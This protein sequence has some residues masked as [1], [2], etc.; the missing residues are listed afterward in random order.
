MA[1]EGIPQPTLKG[2]DGREWEIRVRLAE[3]VAATEYVLFE[4]DTEKHKELWGKIAD[5][6]AD[7]KPELPLFKI[8]RRV[9]K[10]RLGPF[11][12]AFILE[13]GREP[14]DRDLDAEWLDIRTQLGGFA[15]WLVVM[16]FLASSEGSEFLAYMNAM[17]PTLQKAAQERL[18]ATK[19]AAK[20]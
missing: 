3:A 20:G 12:T 15:I 4:L 18:E 10:G 11:L 9:L 1:S 5:S 8:L 13:K 2:K 6:A 16:A 7:G 19:E 17:G 14:V